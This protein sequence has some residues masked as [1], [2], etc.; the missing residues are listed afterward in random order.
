MLEDAMVRRLS[1]MLFV[2]LS[3]LDATGR[4]QGVSGA[5]CPWIRNTKSY[6]GDWKGEGKGPSLALHGAGQ[7]SLWKLGILV[8][9]SPHLVDLL[10]GLV[11][12]HLIMPEKK[13]A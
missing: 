2:C 13:N 7:G 8:K 11:F 9:R 10:V 1:K 6:L 4:Q 12:K 5:L 3:E